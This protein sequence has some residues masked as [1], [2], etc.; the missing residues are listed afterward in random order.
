MA[1]APVAWYFRDCITVTFSASFTSV[2]ANCT[3][4]GKDRQR[5]RAADGCWVLLQQQQHKQ[6]DAVYLAP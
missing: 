1:M 4:A 5:L 2:N 6:V 3:H